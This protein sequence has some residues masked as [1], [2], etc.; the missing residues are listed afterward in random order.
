M[1]IHFS[2]NQMGSV[3]LLLF[4]ILFTLII[5]MFELV[6]NLEGFDDTDIPSIKTLQKLFDVMIQDNN[7]I[8]SDKSIEMLSKRINIIKNNYLSDN[9]NLLNSIDKEYISNL[10][11]NYLEN[12][13][14]NFQL[15]NSI[16]NVE[17]NLA[18]QIKNITDKIKNPRPSPT[19]QEYISNLF[20][21]YLENIQE[22]LKIAKKSDNNRLNRQTIIKQIKEKINTVLQTTQS[23]NGNT[24]IK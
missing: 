11:N 2:S 3:L 24:I 19:D 18:T 13:Q 23:S 15:F 1:S 17:T 20:N 4:I 22:K 12:M 9:Y 5:P 7:F 16:L 21:G 8:Q 6:S 10:L 14:A